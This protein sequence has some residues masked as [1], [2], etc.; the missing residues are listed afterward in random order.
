MAGQYYFL[1]TSLPTLPELGEPAPLDQQTVIRLNRDTLYSAGVFDLDAGPVTIT[2]PDSG[3][4]FMS[5][6]VINEDHYTPAVIYQPG[7]HTFT[8]DSVGTRYMV[9]AFRT[10]VDPIPRT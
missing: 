6:Q 10:L 8:R 2:L 7:S 5:L 4:R 9:A 1:L 3:Q